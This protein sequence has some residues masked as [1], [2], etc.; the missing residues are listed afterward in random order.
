MFGVYFFEVFKNK[1]R[2][3]T[4]VAKLS[5]IILCELGFHL[6]VLY[7]GRD[8]KQKVGGADFYGM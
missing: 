7:R 5:G 6:N 1:R 8:T 4:C 3:L 2:T